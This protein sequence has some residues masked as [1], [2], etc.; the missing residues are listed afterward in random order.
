MSGHNFEAELRVIPLGGCDVIL[1]ADWMW[2]FSPVTFEYKEGKFILCKNGRKLTLKRVDDSI[3]V[4]LMG[5]KGFKKFFMKA[6]HCL[7][8][9]LFALTMSDLQSESNIPPGIQLLL[10]IF[11]DVLQEPLEC[12]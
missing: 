8:A 11:D 7:V 9:Q 4:H 10:K 3:A 2:T 5:F 12:H 6:S 1:G